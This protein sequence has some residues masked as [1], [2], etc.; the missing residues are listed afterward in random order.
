MSVNI[1]QSRKRMGMVMLVTAQED[2]YQS[3]G[4]KYAIFFQFFF[5]ITTFVLL[6]THE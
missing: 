1:F 2:I 5:F 4:L 6:S 3:P